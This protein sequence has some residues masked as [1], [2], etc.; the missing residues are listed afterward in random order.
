[1]DTHQKSTWWR[2]TGGLLKCLLRRK[3]RCI[4]EGKYNTG[5]SQRTKNQNIENLS[6]IGKF[7][8]KVRSHENFKEFHPLKPR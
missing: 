7:A 6:I 5:A 8:H 1:M 3:G 4:M 2:V